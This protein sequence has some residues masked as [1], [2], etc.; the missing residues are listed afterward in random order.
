MKKWLTIK[1]T[2]EFSNYTGFEF[3]ST[4]STSALHVHGGVY[5]SIHVYTRKYLDT[6]HSQITY[7]LVRTY[8]YLA[9]CEWISKPVR[10]EAQEKRSHSI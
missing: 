8:E 1:C 2:T 5:I 10:I 7:A 6:I 9:K 4:S 3:A